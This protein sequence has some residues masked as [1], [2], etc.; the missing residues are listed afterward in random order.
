MQLHPLPLQSD[1]DISAL[2]RTLD[3]Q[4]LTTVSRSI[5]SSKR[6]RLPP[7]EKFLDTFIIY[8]NPPHVGRRCA[9]L[10]EAGVRRMVSKSYD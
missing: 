2:E 1:P 7:L 4:N 10:T 8:R 6:D 5:N 3:L 9:P